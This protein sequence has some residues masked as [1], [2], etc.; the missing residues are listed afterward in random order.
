M[1]ANLPGKL[2]IIFS[3]LTHMQKLSIHERGTALCMVLYSILL[4]VGNAKVC[5][6]VCVYVCMYCICTH[7]YTQTSQFALYIC[8]GASDRN[9]FDWLACKLMQTQN[10]V[11]ISQS[12]Y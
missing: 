3:F 5:L 7:M 9:M 10:K 8:A 4:A 11:M 2:L 1:P 6:Y 12:L